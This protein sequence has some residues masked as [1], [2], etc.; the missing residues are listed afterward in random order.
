M[1]TELT[2]SFVAFCQTSCGRSSKV[3]SVKE[4]LPLL[5]C[6]RDV[7]AHLARLNVARRDI[8]TES[9]LTLARTGN[10]EA[11]ETQKTIC[12]KHRD[13]LGIQ[14]KPGVKCQHPLSQ[15]SKMRQSI[16]VSR[17]VLQFWNVLVPVGSGYVFFQK[18]YA[19]SAVLLKVWESEYTDR[20]KTKRA[21]E[22]QQ[23][24]KSASSVEALSPVFA[25]EQGR[26]AVKHRGRRLSGK[27]IWVSK[28]AT[29]GEVV[30]DGAF[31]EK[32]YG[33][34]L[35]LGYNAI[36]NVT[37]A[38]MKGKE[39]LISLQLND[40]RISYIETGAFN[41]CIELRSFDLQSNRLE[42]ITYDVFGRFRD[43]IFMIFYNNTISKIEPRA[44]DFGYN[45]L[46]L[47]VNNLTDV[48]SVHPSP[49]SSLSKLLLGQN[50]ITKF[51]PDILV[52]RRSLF[53]LDI[54]DISLGRITVDLLKDL[55]Q[56]VL[57]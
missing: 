40:N 17:E 34:E 24:S 27:R 52:G 49:Y 14:W 1:A 23:A 30:E 4:F 38:D 8:T 21:I 45:E 32:G 42:E 5:S 22:P 44:L 43:I 41:A 47:R 35:D 9:A 15:A 31:W 48:S 37:A 29:G 53:Y 56:L 51:S 36:T 20:P 54:S 46:D 19:R 13:A 12:P 16:K 57:L 3:P 18:L 55:N 6:K 10:F 39:M 50:K 28:I 7:G 33:L 11:S 25:L 2:C 26:V